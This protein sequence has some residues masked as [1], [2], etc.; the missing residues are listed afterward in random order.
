MNTVMTPADKK[1]RSLMSIGIILASLGL[2]YAPIPG[3]QQTIVV[4]AGTE[5]AEPLAEIESEFE[6]QNGHIQVELKFQGAQD[7]VN[8]YID[9]KNDFMPTVLMPANG[10]ILDELRDRQSNQSQVEPFVDPPQAIAKTLLVGVAWPERGDIL[11]PQGNFQW[12]AIEDAMQKRSWAAIGGKKNWGSF[13]FIMTDPTRSNS[14]QETLSL[15]AQNKLGG[16]VPEKSGLNQPNIQSLITLVENSV[17]QPPR[18]SDILLQEFITRGPNEADVGT[19]YESIALTRWSQSQ[20]SQG[21]PYQIYYLDP[22]IE[23]EVT[24]VILRQEVSDGQINAAKEWVSFLM[25]P[26]QQET[27]VRFGFR[28]IDQEI[29]LKSV[30][31]SP[32][33]ENIPGAQIQPTGRVFPPPDAELSGEIQR[34]WQRAN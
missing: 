26:E 14:G 8:N 13:D 9:R 10:K 15:W 1:N 29:D 23:S 5:V 27:F 22:T 31:D 33:R 17:Y 28:P 32:W 11:F 21:T 6:R 30:T 18:S 19:T 7:M 12:Q 16:G 34:L 2:A 25:Q 20:Q 3:L 24:A 4:V